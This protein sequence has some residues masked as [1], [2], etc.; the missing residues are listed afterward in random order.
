MTPRARKLVVAGLIVGGDRRVLITQRRADQALGG[1]WEFPGGK[2]EPGEAPVDAL[3]RELREE[4]GVTVAVGR[5][6]DVLF[7]AYPEFDLVMLVYVCR[8]V[9]ESAHGADGVPR[10]VEVAD[11]AWVDAGDLAAWDILPADRPLVE[12]LRVEG[13]PPN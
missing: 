10:A 2:V 12:R 13:V 9:A 5:I 4:I 1:Q 11:L 8:I 6:W 7:H 3:V